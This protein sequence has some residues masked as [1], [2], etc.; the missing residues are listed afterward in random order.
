MNIT[1]DPRYNIG[2]IRLNK[3]SSEVQSIPVGRNVNVDID[4]EGNVY[5]IELLDVNEQ[6]IKDKRIVITDESTGRAYEIPLIL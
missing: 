5:G 3:K 1:C 4:S 6:L 2:Y